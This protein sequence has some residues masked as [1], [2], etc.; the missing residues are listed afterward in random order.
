MIKQIQLLL[1]SL[2]ICLTLLFSSVQQAKASHA[3]GADITY[4]CLSGNTYKVRV[5]FY[6]DCIGIAAPPSINLNVKSISCGRNF[7]ITCDTIPGTGKEVTALCPTAQ[8][9][10]NGGSYTGIQEWVYE[11]IVTLPVQCTDW[12]FSWTYCCRNA[13]ITTISTPGASTFYIY[14]TLNNTIAQ[15][16]NSPTF[17]N[18]PVPFACIGQQFQFNHGAEPQV[19]PVR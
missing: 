18:K 12:T 9:T 17:T 4:V 7:G 16:N 2:F 14:A 11:A 19:V 8:T 5:T 15:C 3:M 13:A 6:R 1:G 10:C